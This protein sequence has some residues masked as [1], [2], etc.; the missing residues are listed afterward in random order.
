MSISKNITSTF[1]LEETHGSINNFPLVSVIVATYRRDITLENALISIIEQTYDFIEIILIDDNAEEKWNGKVKKIVDKLNNNYKLNIKFTRNTINKGS[2]E[3]R[4]IGI[5]EATGE[6]ITFLDDDDIYLPDKIKNQITHMLMEES[7]FSITDLFLYDENDKLVEK[8]NRTYIKKYSKDELIRY[9]LMFHMTGT[10][11]IMFRREYLLNIG[12]FDPINI[13]DEFYLMHKAIQFGGA[14][15]YLP[16][17]D[18]KAI[19]H[20]VTDGL[21]SGLNK[22]NGEIILYKY[23]KK[24]FHKLNRRD[25]R[26]INMR[27]KAVLAFAELRRSNYGTFILYSCHSL[28]SSPMDCLRLIYYLKKDV[29]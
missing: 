13:G 22:I 19:V 20:T 15:S 9:H 10:D 7:D 24:Y 8:R 14:F 18:V 25:I 5:N 11:T 4:N 17:C 16:V 21:S 1:F 28:I 27:H 2:A 3:T 23:K 12:G 6:Y 29:S 26:Y